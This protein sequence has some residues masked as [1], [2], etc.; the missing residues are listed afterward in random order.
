MAGDEVESNVGLFSSCSCP[1]RSSSE[2][3]ELFLAD[4]V[5]LDPHE[6]PAK[7]DDEPPPPKGV[8]FAFLGFELLLEV[9]PLGSSPHVSAPQL[10]ATP[11]PLLEL[12]S[13][14]QSL[15]LEEPKPPFPPP[16]LSDG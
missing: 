1:Q 14:L 15:L 11:E 16:R 9:V 4:P 12:L 2:G 6:S 3:L 8:K 7:P 13:L 10:D 5:D